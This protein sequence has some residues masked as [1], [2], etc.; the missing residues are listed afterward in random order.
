MTI[1]ETK[2]NKISAIIRACRIITRMNQARPG[3][4]KSEVRYYQMLANYY[5]RVLKAKEE[6]KFLAAHT[7]FFPAEI[8]YA[9]DIVPM[10]TEMTTWMIALFL[11]EQADI[12]SAGGDLGLVPEICSPH[13]G[14][15]GAFSLG[16][17]PRPD[18]MLWSNLVC[19][20]TAKSGELIMALN[21]CPGFYLDHPF[22]NS[23]AEEKYLVGELREMI[24]FLEEKSGQ[25]MDWDKLSEIVAGMDRQM[26]LFREI[27]ELRQAVPSPFHFRG[28]LELLTA[29]YLCPGQPEAIAYLETVRDELAEMVR[30]GKGAVSQE[31]FRLMTLFIPPMYL[32]GFLER[33][34]QEYGAVS[35]VEPFFTRWVEGRL[36]PSRPLESVAKKASLIPER[37]TMYGPLE[38][39]TVKDI[40]GCAKQYQVDGAIYWAFIGCRHTCATIRLFKDVLNEIGVPVLVLDCDIVDPTLNSEEEI[41]GKLEQFFELLS[42]GRPLVTSQTK[43]MALGIDVGSLTTK[44]VLLGDDGILA[45]NVIPSTEEAEV[46]ARTAMEKVLTKAG[47]NLNNDFPVVSTGVG[48][49]LVSFSQQQTAI[50]TC[51]ARG[52]HHLFP[53]VRMVIDMGAESSTVVKV[54][55]QGHPTDWAN[56]DKC[57]AGTGLF[58]QQMAKLMQMP[59]EEMSALAFQARSRAE[60]SSTCAVFAESEVI[61]HVHREPPTP[62]ADIVAGIYFSVVSRIISL[63]KRLGIEKDVAVVGGVALNQGLVHILEKGLGFKVLVPDNPQV[64]VALGAAIMARENLAKGAS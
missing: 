17:L 38:E 60:I 35:V 10:H 30:Q 41:R 39:R 20:N 25:K 11:G 59:L 32:M 50:T 44:A 5:H 54:N 2:N 56:Q 55:E 4:L 18:V 23:E 61:S 63:C 64:V 19:D 28:F 13:R 15:A 27:N 47:L 6:G 49:K 40:I 58:L 57:A 52:I 53:S 36:D 43:T 46:V 29:D 45:A 7:V 16:V 48:G 33:I 26:A 14:I 51:L 42:T 9:M 3:A 21:H 8:L 31:R 62:K 12:L 37:Y 24:R 1:S 22:Q 34:S